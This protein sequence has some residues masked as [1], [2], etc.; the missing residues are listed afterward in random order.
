MFFAIILHNARERE[1][2]QR[3]RNTRI[4]LIFGVLFCPVFLPAA[5][6]ITSDAT[7]EN[8]SVV[9]VLPTDK[10]FLIDQAGQFPAM[11]NQTISVEL[12]GNFDG[13]AKSLYGAIANTLNK[14]IKTFNGRDNWTF[15][16]NTTGVTGDNG[17]LFFAGDGGTMK[18]ETNLKIELVAGSNIGKGVFLSAAYNSQNPAGNDQVGIFEFKKG[19][20]ID[21]TGAVGDKYIFNIDQQKGEMYVNYNKANG[22]PWGNHEIKLKGDFRIDG[23]DAILAMNLNSPNAHIEGKED[24]VKGTFN[25]NLS[26]GGKWRVTSGDATITNLT[27]NNATDPTTSA[28]KDSTQIDSALSMIDLTTDARRQQGFQATQNINIGTLSGNN[29]VFRI[30][31]DFPNQQ[32]DLITIDK[33]AAG[34]QTHY[35]QLLQKKGDLANITQTRQLVVAK[36]MNGGDDLTFNALPVNLSLIHI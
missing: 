6:T 30:M 10:N 26:N 7:K 23:K 32:G 5:A 15:S 18:F 11:P 1:V 8:I 28:D 36:I 35:I 27:I 20:N 24:Y 29:G 16:I 14:Q 12:T 2:S 22:N 9:G 31:I 33:K 3:L 17:A 25:L 13:G 19:L 21:T 4:Q 34:Q